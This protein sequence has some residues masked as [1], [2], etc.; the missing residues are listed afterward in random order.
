M[1]HFL[2][3][4]GN[5]LETKKK[6]LVISQCHVKHFIAKDKQKLSYVLLPLQEY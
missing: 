2:K 1:Y 3:R 6:K 4:K 5:L